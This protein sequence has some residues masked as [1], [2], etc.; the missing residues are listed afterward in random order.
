VVLPRED[1][2]RVTDLVKRKYRIGWALLG[3][4]DLWKRV[5]GKSDEDTDAAIK[6]TLNAD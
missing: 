1:V 2:Q 6:V 4:M 5:T 3:A